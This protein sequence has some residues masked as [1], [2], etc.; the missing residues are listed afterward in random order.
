MFSGWD[1]PSHW[2]VLAIVVVV[3]FGYR[4]LPDAARSVG[5]SLRIFK[6]EMKGLTEDDKAREA[7][8]ADAAGDATPSVMPPAEAPVAPEVLPEPA[9]VPETRSESDAAQ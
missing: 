4:K 2:L 5:R 6:T 8:R 7:A 3:L 1:R 9:E